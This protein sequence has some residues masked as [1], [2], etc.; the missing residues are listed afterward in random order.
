[1]KKLILVC[2][3][4]ALITPCP[5]QRINATEQSPEVNSYFRKSKRQ[6]TAAIVLL[7]GGVIM[8]LVGG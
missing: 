6:S 4:L 3:M 7:S 8:N 5:A 1:M 2:C